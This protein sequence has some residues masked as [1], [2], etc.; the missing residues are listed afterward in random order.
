ML[1]AYIA[2]DD[3]VVYLGFGEDGL[4]EF[5]FDKHRSKYAVFIGKR[6]GD[7]NSCLVDPRLLS[8]D[9]NL[10]PCGERFEML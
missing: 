4:G 6:Q 8:Q 1:A 5:F 7:T 10:E 2:I 9:L 3:I